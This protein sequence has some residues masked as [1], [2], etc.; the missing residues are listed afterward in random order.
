MTDTS[1]ST[2]RREALAFW[3]LA[4][5]AL[6]VAHDAIHLVQIGPG[7]ALV[8]ALRTAGHGYWGWVSAA[9]TT[10]A[11]LGAIST[12]LLIRHLRRRASRLGV[13]PTAAGPFLIRFAGAWWRLGAVVAIGFAAQENGEHLITHGHALGAGALVGPEYPLAIPVISFI[14]ALGGAVAAVISGMR[15]GLVAAI[16][17][18]LRRHVRPVRRTTR[19]PAGQR[20]AID[21]VLAHPGAGRAPPELFV[22]AT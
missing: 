2:A 11:V 9:L 1:R 15:E 3:A 7:Q 10:V 16:E 8:D 19:R 17:A 4:G 20:V 22:S 5:L 6:F 12:A 21:S 14:S 13:A 18:A